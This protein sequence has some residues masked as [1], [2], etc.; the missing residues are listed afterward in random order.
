M[1][2]GAWRLSF[3]LSHSRG[4]T[5]GHPATTGLDQ[6]GTLVTVEEHAHKVEL[7]LTRFELGLSRSLGPTWDTVLRVPYFIKDQRLEVTHESGHLSPDEVEAAER[8]AN[9]HHRTERYHGFSDL[10]WSVGWRKS[11]LGWL[12]ND[13]VI[14]LSLGVTLP[15]GDTEAD[16][17]T[18]GDAGLY[19]NHLQFGNGTFDPILDA[20][21]GVPLTDTWA[22]SVYGKARIP[23]YDNVEGYHGGVEAMLVP[24][25]TWLP[26]K[27]LSLSVGASIA[28]FGFAEWSGVRDPNSGQLAINSYLSVGYKWSESLTTSLTLLL[29]TYT[30]TFSGEDSLTSAPTFSLS[31]AWSF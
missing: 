22:V 21:L 23:L 25:L 3:D 7:D 8:S 13:A 18:A 29:P 16:P 31:A 10:E 9:S 30:D 15:V 11:G 1:D 17:L 28:Y 6:H 14:R 12:G 5:G 19:H 4:L 24:R 20:Y 2:E 26:Q 27:N